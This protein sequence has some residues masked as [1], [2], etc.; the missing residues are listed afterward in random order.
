M[1]KFMLMLLSLSFFGAT[2]MA[3]EGAL[4]PT[5]DGGANIHALKGACPEKPVKN[6]NYCTPKGASCG[7]GYDQFAKLCWGGWKKGFVKCGVSCKPTEQCGWNHTG[8]YKCSRSLEHA[9]DRKLTAVS[10]ISGA[11]KLTANGDVQV[12]AAKNV[13]EVQTPA[14]GDEPEWTVC[15]PADGVNCAPG[16]KRMHKYCWGGFKKGLY[17]CGYVCEKSRNANDDGNGGGIN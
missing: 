14:A 8:D 17:R 6:G 16:Y 1:K 4:V 3:F 7:P 9:G 5:L 10:S 15:R 12:L 11:L 2:A 13:C